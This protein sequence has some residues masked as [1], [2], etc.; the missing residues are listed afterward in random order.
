MQ[1]AL[2]N[3]SSLGKT[4]YCVFALNLFLPYVIEVIILNKGKAN[5]FEGD[6]A[7]DVFEIITIFCMLYNSRTRKNTKLLKYAQDFL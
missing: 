1:A 3:L 4:G 6:L 2:V 5:S 7:K